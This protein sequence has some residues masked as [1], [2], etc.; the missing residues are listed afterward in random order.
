MPKWKTLF[1]TPKKTAVTVACILVLLATVGTATVYAANAFA[2]SSAI[3]GEEAANFA[4]ADAGVDPVSATGLHVE[5]DR[6]QGRFVYEVE[7]AADGTEYK[8]LIDSTD[9]SVVK[10][11]KETVS[12][13]QE[14]GAAGMTP[15]RTLEEAREIA[16]ADAGVAADAA[17]FSEAGL[18]QDKGLWVY[19]FK[20]QAGDSQFEYEINAN[21][22]DVYSKSVKTYVTPNPSPTQSTAP[23]PESAA[24]PAPGE[25]PAARP[26]DTLP[27]ADSHHPDDQNYGG[28]RSTGTAPGVDLETAKA[29]AL[30]DAGVSADGAVFTK[31]KLDWEDGV[32]VY[33]IEFYTSTHEYE[34]EISASTGAVYNRSAEA[35]HTSVQDP[36]VEST[37]GMSTGSSY[38]GTTQAKSIALDHAGLSESQVM[39]TKAGLDRDDGVMVYEIEFR[40][41]RTEYEYK[42]DAQTGTILEHETD[43]D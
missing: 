26:S 8:Y 38:I 25:V 15:S 36:P 39:V 37:P 7:F 28:D 21:T 23:A 10:R 4:F 6:E 24:Q 17:V 42:I 32:Q 22:G 27:P 2:R 19:E 43:R 30:A 18:D 33:E 1:E 35:F 31:T 12:A 34:Y 14:S 5:F 3:G 13:P 20:F 40:Q 29:A 16:L 41:G 9:G 11:E